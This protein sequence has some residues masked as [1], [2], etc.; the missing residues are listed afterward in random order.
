MAGYQLH[1]ER[2][3]CFCRYY[4]PN[5]RDQLVAKGMLP[6][7][8]LCAMVTMQKRQ[9]DEAQVFSLPLV[10]KMD[11]PSGCQP[12]PS[13]T[14]ART[15]THSHTHTYTHEN[16]KWLIYGF[17]YR[18][19]RCVYSIQEPA[20]ETWRKEGW[21]SCFPAGDIGGSDPQSVWTAGSSKVQQSYNYEG[22]EKLYSV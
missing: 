5:V 16:S 21:G 10:P 13:G 2:W 22:T 15:H 20:S 7:S 18:L 19:A 3:Q 1:V 4:Y 11:S 17:P 12:Q 14:H 8:K 6:L 9:P